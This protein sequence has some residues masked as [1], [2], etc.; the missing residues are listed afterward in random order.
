MAT[1]FGFCSVPSD[2]E[3]VSITLSR[4][5]RQI[6]GC[7]FSLSS[8]W[9]LSFH[10]HHWF[11][12]VPL[13]HPRVPCTQI[14]PPGLPGPACAKLPS[15]RTR[16]GAWWHSPRNSVSFRKGAWWDARTPRRPSPAAATGGVRVPK[17]VSP[18]RERC[19]RTSLSPCLLH[20]VQTEI[21]S[22]M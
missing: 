15:E 8:R 1:Y 6:L 22:R 7:C 16:E 3:K 20:K 4:A 2:K 10:P 21:T 19:H 17:Q 12:A 9:D 5:E 18:G 13:W 11:R 14:S